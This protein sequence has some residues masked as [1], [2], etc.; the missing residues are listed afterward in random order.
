MIDLLT[1]LQHSLGVDQ[2]GRGQQ[3]REHFCAGPGHAD[4]ETCCEAV[5]KG[6]MVRRDG[7]SVVGGTMFYVTP[8]GRKWM[9][10][11]SPKPPKLTRAQARYQRY[12]DADCG[13][14]FG[15]WLQTRWAA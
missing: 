4:F 13:L 9:A 10:E 8:A 6:L 3:Y 5:D 12:L 7:L 2:Y 14:S 15:E 11:N 1:I